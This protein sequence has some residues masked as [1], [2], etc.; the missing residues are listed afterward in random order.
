MRL[1]HQKSLQWSPPFLPL[2]C[3]WVLVSSVI[4]YEAFCL[5]VVPIFFYSPYIVQNLGYTG[6][7]KSLCAPDDYNTESYK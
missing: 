3:V 6:W 1:G 5:H 7:S 2:F 4:C